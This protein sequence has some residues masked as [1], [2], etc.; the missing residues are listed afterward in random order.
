MWN[1]QLNIFSD[2][3]QL[4]FVSISFPVNL[5][6]GVKSGETGV[7]GCNLLFCYKCFL[8]IKEQAYDEETR[9]KDSNNHY[10]SHAKGCSV[11]KLILKILDKKQ[12]TANF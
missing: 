5:K 2:K 8:K 10:S 3:G 11:E 6:S 12:I 9:N 4:H 1:N 7:Q